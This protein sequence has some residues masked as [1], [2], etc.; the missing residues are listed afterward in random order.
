M[1]DNKLLAKYGIIVENGAVSL[2]NPDRAIQR[3]LRDHR[4]G[5]LQFIAQHTNSSRCDE[6]GW[7]S[8]HCICGDE[9]NIS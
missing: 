8:K 6:C 1:H 2:L 3:V 5:L 7:D 4:E 9:K